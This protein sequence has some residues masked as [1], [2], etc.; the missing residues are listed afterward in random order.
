ML[1]TM[2]YLFQNSYR[3]YKRRK[4]QII[5]TCTYSCTFL[6]F[7]AVGVC[8]CGPVCVYLLRIY[9][10]WANTRVVSIQKCAC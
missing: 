3:F 2:G 8:V 1:K 10:I 6:A 5:I 9:F 7:D 4:S